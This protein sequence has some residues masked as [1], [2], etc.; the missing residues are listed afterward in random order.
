M[1]DRW[2]FALWPP[3][4]LR[5][6][7]CE[8]MPGWLPPGGRLAH[9][10]DLHL[11]LVFL[12]ALTPSQRDP[13]IAAADRV[14][15]APFELVLRCLGHFP[16]VGVAW[17]GPEPEP[18]ALLQLHQALVALQHECRLPLERRPYRPHLTLARRS[19]APAANF[20]SPL[21]WSV[22]DFVLARSV[23]G[24]LPRYRVERRWPLRPGYDLGPSPMQ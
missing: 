18:S 8:R 3:P 11:T 17:C 15:G 9:G 6:A 19:G 21:S 12:G 7:L 10:E 1:V 5:R 20:G 2:F 14:A 16:R 23:P 13:V 22:G 4:A 24:H